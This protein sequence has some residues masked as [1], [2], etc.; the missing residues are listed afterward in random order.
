[1]REPR[2]FT[3][4]SVEV[5]NIRDLNWNEDCPF[6]HA[7]VLTATTND[8][9]RFTNLQAVTKQMLDDIGEERLKQDMRDAVHVPDES[10]W[11][12]EYRG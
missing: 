10:E 6:D 5:Y 11:R 4:E 9:R 3:I 1:M 7:I 8:G 12:E 2:D